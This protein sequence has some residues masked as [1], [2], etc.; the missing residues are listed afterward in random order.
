M[1]FCRSITARSNAG[2]FL[3]LA[4]QGQVV[5]AQGRQA[6]EFASLFPQAADTPKPDRP[7]IAL[8]IRGLGLTHVSTVRFTPHPGL[9]Q[10][11]V[12]TW[13]GVVVREGSAPAKPIVTIGVASTEALSC[14]GLAEIGD[15]SS[16]AV[17]A[18]LGLVYRTRS[19]N[20]VSLTPL[21]VVRDSRSGEWRIDQT[22]SDEISQQRGKASLKA[23]RGFLSKH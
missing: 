18:R 10:A 16:A 12:T 21:I 8:K 4:A 15:V 7:E 23:I 22:L 1:R 5:D 11:V 9:S 3:L 19:A 6:P 13:C 14:D 2:A 17:P 20:A